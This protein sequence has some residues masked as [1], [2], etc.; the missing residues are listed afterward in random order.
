LYKT[1]LN[2]ISYEEHVCSVLFV[3]NCLFIGA[4][5]KM[6]VNASISYNHITLYIDQLE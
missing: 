5:I 6:Y 4:Y 1:L 2:D 3:D